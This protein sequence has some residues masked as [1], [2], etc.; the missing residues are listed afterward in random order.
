MQVRLGG[1]L[2]DGLHLGSAGGSKS[3]A[4]SDQAKARAWSGPSSGE[5]GS[6]QTRPP[7]AG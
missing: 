5:N 2:A 4:A 1:E 6:S 7:A 3:A